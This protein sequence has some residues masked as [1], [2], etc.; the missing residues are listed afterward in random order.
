MTAN[1]A[2]RQERKG[3]QFNGADAAEQLA[4]ALRKEGVAA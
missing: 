2:P 3:V 1:K 4:A